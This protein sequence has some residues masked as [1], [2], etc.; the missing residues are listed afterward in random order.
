[1]TGHTLDIQAVLERLEK[2]EKERKRSRLVGALLVLLSAVILFGG[3]AQPPPHTLA[4][5][6][7][8]LRD[9]LGR[10]RASLSV[11]SKVVA[12]AFFDETGRKQM[13]LKATTDNTGHG[14][15]SLGL[16]EGGANARYILAGTDPEGD[17]ATISD[18]GVLLGAKDKTHVLLSASGPDSPSLEISDSRGYLTVLGVSEFQD[19]GTGRTQRTSAASLVLIDKDG[20]VIWSDPVGN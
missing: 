18:G 19:P 10:T 8:I 1:M 13:L 16:G 7:F 14:H 2:L 11:D 17:L 3:A 15:A 12:L 5:D 20:N 6:E 4:A 9:S